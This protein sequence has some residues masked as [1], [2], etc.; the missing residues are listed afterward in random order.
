[1]SDYE[2]GFASGKRYALDTRSK[3]RRAVDRDGG[4]HD[5]LEL[6]AQDFLPPELIEQIEDRVPP[7]ARAEFMRGFRDGVQAF[8]VGQHVGMGD[9]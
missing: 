1:M 5:M 9:N 6:A 4:E 7:E 3:A 8:L 2:Q